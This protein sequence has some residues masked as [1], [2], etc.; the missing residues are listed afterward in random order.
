MQD[1][2][3]SDQARA[4]AAQVPAAIVTRLHIAVDADRTLTRTDRTVSSATQA[5]I[6]AVYAAGG[7]M[8]LCTG[9]QY[10][11]L[12]NSLMQFF[13]ESATHVVSGGAGS[14]KTTGELIWEQP[15]PGAL[16]LEL[17][18][19]AQKNHCE[20]AFGL[21]AVIYA[22]AGLPQRFRKSYGD[23]IELGDVS[24]LPTILKTTSVQAVFLSKLNPAMQQTLRAHSAEIDYREMA[25]YEGELYVDVTAKG[26]NK[27][28]GLATLARLQ[29]V[30][31]DEIITVGDEA[32]DLEMIR[33]GWGVA[34]GN[35][36]P[37]LKAVAKL[38]VDHTDAD[39]LAQ[40]VMALI[41]RRQQLG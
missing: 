20:F 19:E 30:P 29:H 28:S 27:A 34:M 8:H 5:A 24:Q 17:V 14:I 26:V 13:P 7:Q 22:S 40:F 10:S 11:V 4:F 15:L 16:V 2:P 37:E 31:L 38:T 9:R 32:N 12:R 18:N 23:A 35:A 6:R 39:G 41:E 1:F 3:L 25:N 21:G 33:A 36:I